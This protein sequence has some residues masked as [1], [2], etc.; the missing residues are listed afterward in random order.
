[1][2]I[3]LVDGDVRLAVDKDLYEHNGASGLCAL[4][5]ATLHVFDDKLYSSATHSGFT[6]EV[7]RAPK[8]I[9]RE[10]MMSTSVTTRPASYIDIS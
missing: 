9:L 5:I 3:Y 8:R 1:M 7:A 4:T 6:L 10:N 2:W